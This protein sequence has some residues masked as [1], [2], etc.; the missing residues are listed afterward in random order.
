MTFRRSSAGRH[1]QAASC[2]LLQQRAHVGFHGRRREAVALRDVGNQLRRRLAL[3]ETRPDLGADPVELEAVAAGHV[4]QNG[5]V[6]RSLGDDVWIGD[7]GLPFH[8]SS[9]LNGWCSVKTEA[10]PK[11]GVLGSGR[12]CTAATPSLNII[13]AF[14]RTRSARRP[15]RTPSV[16][17]SS[18]GRSWSTSAA[19]LE[20]CRILPAEPAL[21][22]STAS[23]KE[24]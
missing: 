21:V 9:V 13:A 14:L 18:P 5:S 10:A 22:A 11:G 15:S 6:V 7:E 20:S 16:K 8:R 12:A 17:R 19:E 4:H 1:Q 23:S 3:A 24:R 2:Q